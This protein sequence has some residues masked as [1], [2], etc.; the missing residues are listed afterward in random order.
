MQE[1]QLKQHRKEL[2]QQLMN[3]EVLRDPQKIKALSIE[4]GKVEK[5]LRA[6]KQG[7]ST[8]DASQKI[9]MEIRAGAGGEEA[10]LFASKLFHM[11]T[12]YAKRRGWVSTLIDT[13]RTTLGGIKEAAIEIDGTDAYEKLRHES[14]VHRVQRIP[15]TEKSGRIHTSTASVAVLPE[16]RAEEMEVRP[17]D[18]KIEFFRSSGPGGQN[19]NKVE[20]G[21]RLI[22][23]P[24]G[25][26]ISSH[27]SRSQQQNRDRAMTMLRTKLLDAQRRAEEEKKAKERREQI[28]T[29]ERVEKIRTYNF[30]QDR[31]TDH[32]IKESWHNIEKILAGELDPLIAT[33]QE[34]ILPHSE[35]GRVA[36]K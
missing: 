20:T 6:L 14:G 2:Q 13:N 19:V 22:H 32:R 36:P 35:A 34:K 23:L 4:L 26:V 27:E 29:A 12:S 10:A 25:L 28:G 33:I 1:E 17:Q 21:V 7:G 3:P 9:I 24:T 30:P 8:P 16:A 11:Y 5:E 15:E 18:I 31:V